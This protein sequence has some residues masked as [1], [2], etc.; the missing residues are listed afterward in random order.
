MGGGFVPEAAAVEVGGETPRRILVKVE[1]VP[2]GVHLCKQYGGTWYRKV[3]D[4]SIKHYVPVAR[5][6]QSFGVT[7]YGNITAILHGKDVWVIPPNNWKEFEPWVE[8]MT[9]YAGYDPDEDYV[10]H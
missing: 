1:D 8:L 7:D 4:D 2:D 10:P 3:A 6:Q 9:K 5:P